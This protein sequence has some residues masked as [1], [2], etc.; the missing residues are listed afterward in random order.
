MFQTKISTFI[1]NQPIYKKPALTSC[2]SKTVHTRNGAR[3]LKI[4][5]I[6]AHQQYP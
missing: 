3:I 4:E 5:G 2:P 6:P 1:R